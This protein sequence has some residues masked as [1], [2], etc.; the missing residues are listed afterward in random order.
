MTMI[1]YKYEDN[2]I[3][4]V[5]S[6]GYIMRWDANTQSAF[7]TGIEL[8]EMDITSMTPEE[9]ERVLGVTFVRGSVV[10]MVAWNLAKFDS[11]AGTQFGVFTFASDVTPDDK[12]RLAKAIAEGI[13]DVISQ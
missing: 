4:G 6:D 3:V 1:K 10:V 9:R 2:E 5:D 8:D 12:R 13:D 11:V 7:D